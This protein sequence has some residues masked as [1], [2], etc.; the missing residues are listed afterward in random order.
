M[1]LHLR[2]QD[3]FPRSSLLILLIEYSAISGLSYGVTFKGVPLLDDPFMMPCILGI[4]FPH[5][6]LHLKEQRH[7]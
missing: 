3:L 7:K 5:S 2:L 4:Y 6:N 1:E